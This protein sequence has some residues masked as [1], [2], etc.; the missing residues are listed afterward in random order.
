[1]KIKKIKKLKNL[2]GEIITLI[3]IA[4][5]SIGK[6]FS[7]LLQENNSYVIEGDEYWVSKE[8]YEDYLEYK[9]NEN[10]ASVAYYVTSYDDGKSQPVYEF[11][12]GEKYIYDYIENEY[13]YDG[14][15]IKKRV[16]VYDFCDNKP[17]VEPELV[18]ASDGNLYVQSPDYYLDESGELHTIEG[19][20]K[21][22]IEEKLEEISSEKIKIR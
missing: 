8:S 5:L 17:L 1:M 4:G 7:N 16:P 11:P 15:L 18:K 3:V 20:A 14:E 13:Y 21:E 6:L 9:R 19:S 2:D 10:I 12:Y 22:N